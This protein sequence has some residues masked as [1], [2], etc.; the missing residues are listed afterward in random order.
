MRLLTTKKERVIVMPQPKDVTQRQRI[1]FP[2][3]VAAI[4]LLLVP[5]AGPL[6]AMMMLG[7]LIRECGVVERVARALGGDFLSI[8]TMF[9]GLLIGVT[10]TADNMINFRT[11]LII[12]LGLLAFIFGTIGGILTAKILNVATG[13]KVNPLIGNSGVSAMP[14]AARVSQKIAQQ[15]NPNNYVIM[16]AM[17]PIL[18]STIGSAVV[19]GI[20]ISLFR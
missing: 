4:T 8:T 14:M 11:I 3:L 12:I 5:S 7:N 2:S 1:L 18:A 16:H 9:I 20:L 19:A 10:A 17:G 13:G 15:Y 6:I